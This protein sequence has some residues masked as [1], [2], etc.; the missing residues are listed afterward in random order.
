MKPEETETPPEPS[1]LSSGGLP[2][3]ETETQI[4]HYIETRRGRS[5]SEGEAKR[6]LKIILRRRYALARHRMP[7]RT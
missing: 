7:E 3:A 1:L 2:V 5:N 6:A 4:R